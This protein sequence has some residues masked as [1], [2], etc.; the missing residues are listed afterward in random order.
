MLKQEPV[1][2]ITCKKN[3]LVGH[4]PCLHIWLFISRLYHKQ[5]R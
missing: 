4:T 3:I 1:A 5:Q 2:G